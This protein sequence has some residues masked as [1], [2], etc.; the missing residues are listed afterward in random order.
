MTWVENVWYIIFMCKT[1]IFPV[2][3]F[4]NFL[5]QNIVSI[6]DFKL[7][8]LGEGNLIFCCTSSRENYFEWVGRQN[9]NNPKFQG[10]YI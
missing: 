7:L 8:W 5:L 3:V 2:L 10:R 4:K 6:S 9:D 1:R